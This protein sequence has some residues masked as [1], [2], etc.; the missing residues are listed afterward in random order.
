MAIA[1]AE[2]AVATH[3]GL[4]YITQEVCSDQ[5]LINATRDQAVD[6]WFGIGFNLAD[7]VANVAPLFPNTKFS[8]I[9]TV[10]TDAAGNVQSVLFAED[11]PAFAVGV[12]AGATTST[13]T[14][15]GIF[16]VPFPALR[17][18]RNGFAQGVVHECPTCKV[19]TQYIH[20]FGDLALGGEVATHFIQEKQ[21]D[22]LFGAAGGTSVG[23]LLAA[24]SLGAFVIGVD[25]DQFI[26]VFGGYNTT[27]GQTG[28]PMSPAG[29]KVITSAQK[30]IDTAV[31]LLVADDLAG[32]FTP[33]KIWCAS[34]SG[35]EGAV[36]ACASDPLA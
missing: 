13:K 33:G 24:T 21:C 19:I 10:V 14:V 22:V 4:T 7:P 1:G 8:V 16:G 11:E 5:Q 29:A 2:S 12:L 32:D 6:H 31:E 17:K 34:F 9:D 28:V 15:C 26:S 30:R 18:F 27:G 20:S 3:S 35:G 25:S 36:A 23:A